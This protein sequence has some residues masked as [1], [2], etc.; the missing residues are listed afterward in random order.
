MYVQSMHV[1]HGRNYYYMLNCLLFRDE[2]M[3]ITYAHYQGFHRFF[4]ACASET[5][6]RMLRT[7]IRQNSDVSSLI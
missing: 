5:S 1:M 6:T 4:D 3:C 7:S 2:Y